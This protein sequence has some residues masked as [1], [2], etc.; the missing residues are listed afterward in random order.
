MDLLS[1]DA[2]NTLILSESLDLGIEI[3]PIQQA[4]GRILAEDLLAD[5]DFPPFDRVSMDGIAINYSAF[6]AG[7]RTFEIEG[8][9]AAGNEVKTLSQNSNCLEVMTGA[10]LPQNCDAVIRYEDV[11]I[12]NKLAKLHVPIEIRQNI[13]PKAS[14]AKSGSLLV[15]KNKTINVADLAIA[16]TIGKTQI[17]VKKHP[18]I[19]II[20]S[21]D[22]IVAIEQTPLPHQI[23]SSNVTAI[24]GL[25]AKNGFEA[26]H[27][28]LADDLETTKIEI[29]NTL[30]EFDVLI[31]T[32]GVSMGKKDFIPEALSSNGVEK[33]F[34]KI[35][36][37]PG[38]PMWFG[39]TSKNIV[40][41]LPGN[42]VSTFM[43]TVRYVLPWL[44]GKKTSDF[45]VFLGEDIVFKPKLSYYLQVNLE[46]ENGSMVAYPIKHQGSGDFIN[47]SNASGFI[48]I[49]LSENSVFEKG[50]LY[51]YF[52]I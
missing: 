10:A 27:K 31:L 42:P 51:N 15:A 21:G 37:K 43:C 30:K 14:D 29:K 5:R 34:H 20:S 28:H 7:Q 11:T 40:F 12:E 46:F 8:L 44:L 36:Q 47:L 13:H 48:E 33:L 19:C 49:P 2:A 6:E 38:K 39:K 45:K 32:G 23:R 26:S 50:K 17:L 3:V 35:A 18:K 41:A 22:E 52:K 25:L 9:Q 4:L 24:K 1:V 16:A